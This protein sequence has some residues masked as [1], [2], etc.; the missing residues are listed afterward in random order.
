MAAF[1]IDNLLS[2]PKHAISSPLNSEPVPLMN[3]SMCYP[4]SIQVAPKTGIL[5]TFGQ[6]QFS[7]SSAISKLESHAPEIID[8]SGAVANHGYLHSVETYSSSK[9]GNSP[10]LSTPGSWT[11]GESNLDAQLQ[12][13]GDART[14]EMESGSGCL[15]PLQKDEFG[16]KNIPEPRRMLIKG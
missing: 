7:S 3:T 14:P 10:R 2:K 12:R 13:R 6:C 15:S 9:Q 4:L 16:Q 11:E 5:P 1:S 8:S